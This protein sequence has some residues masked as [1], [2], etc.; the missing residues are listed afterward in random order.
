MSSTAVIIGGARG[1]GG[2]IAE[3]LGKNTTI[4]RL[5]VADIDLASA[6]ETCDRIAGRANATAMFVDLTEEAS[7]ERFVKDTEE[8]DCVVI[9]AGLFSAAPATEVDLDTFRRVLDVNLVGTYHA[10]QL[11][12]SKMVERGGGS[13]VAVASIAARMPRMRQAACA[14]SKAGLRQALRVLAMEVADAGV[15]VN[16]VSPGP[17][18]TE[19]MRSLAADHTSMDDLAMGSIETFR[20]RIP[21]GRV[22]TTTD[23]ANAV[24]F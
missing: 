19:M 9:A 8:A 18:D 22:A 13:I 4:T 21:N 5:I 2:A 16:T 23:I 3:A 10:A 12:A 11:Y 6:R 24:M 17:T 7:V 20:P 15:R 14:A 1:I